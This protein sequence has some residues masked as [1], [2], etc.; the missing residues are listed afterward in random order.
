MALWWIGLGVSF[1]GLVVAWFLLL[2]T[3][4]RVS[5]KAVLFTGEGIETRRVPLI[6]P[7]VVRWTLYVL[8]TSAGGGLLILATYLWGWKF[9]MAVLIMLVAWLLSAL[10]GQLFVCYCREFRFE[11]PRYYSYKGL[12]TIPS[13]VYVGNSHNVSLSLGC[14]SPRIQLE[15][16]V[17][18]WLKER[19][20]AIDAEGGKSVSLTVK[21]DTTF[22]EVELMAAGI[23][24]DGEKVQRQSVNEQV[25]VFVWN[26]HFANS[27]DQRVNLVV[28]AVKGERT[29]PFGCIEQSIRVAQLDGLTRRQV[30]MLGVVIGGVSL[31]S[32][33]LTI[34]K[35]W[36]KDLQ[37]DASAGSRKQSP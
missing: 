36:K 28:K 7:F 20:S 3:R 19:F 14:V 15:D 10:Y 26:C 2:V 6:A 25:L 1:I 21:G 23:S 27:G 11:C 13:R 24:V 35:I 29:I 30:W 9:W 32:S 12:C 16:S 4:T 5:K 31:L 33:I 34:I 22:I 37:E 18:T 8:G 17:D